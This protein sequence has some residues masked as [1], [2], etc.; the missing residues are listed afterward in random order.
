MSN[1]A[2]VENSDHMII[3]NKLP[4]IETKL[5]ELYSP[6]SPINRLKKNLDALNTTLYSGLLSSN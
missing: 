1:V 3:A 2:H 5:Q 4:A 6:K